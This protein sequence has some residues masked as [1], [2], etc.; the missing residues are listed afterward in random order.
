MSL[1]EEMHEARERVRDAARASSVELSEE[2]IEAIANDIVWCNGYSSEDLF[3]A[4]GFASTEGL[5]E[6]LFELG[7]NPDSVRTMKV[8]E[9]QRLL[10]LHRYFEKR[11]YNLDWYEGEGPCYDMLSDYLTGCTLAHAVSEIERL[12]PSE[13]QHA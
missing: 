6:A 13:V 9:A 3:N 11:V 4:I 1:S 8:E 2:A 5:A 12:Y 10:A 7:Y